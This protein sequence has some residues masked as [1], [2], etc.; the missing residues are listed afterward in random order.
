[1]DGE[2]RVLRTLLIDNYDSFT[3][4]LADYLTRINGL[5]PTVIRNDDPSWM[6]G[7][8]RGFDNVVISPGPGNP[9]RDA[10]FGVC[11][12]AIRSARIPLLGVCLGHQGI[13]RVFGGRVRR[14]PEVFHGRPSAVW[15]SG[16]ELFTGIPS[17]F[18]AVRYHS[19]V[20]ADLP[21]DLEPIA[22]TAG[23]VL[24]GLRHRER[25]IWGVQFH[26]ES[27]C[28]EYGFR[29]L[30]NF[31]SLTRERAAGSSEAALEQA[32]RGPRPSAAPRPERRPAYR[33]LTSVV[34]CDADPE[35]IFGSWY[36]G[37]EHAFWLDSSLT[38]GAD[39]EYS[40][41][42][43]ASGP[44]ARVVTADVWNRRVTVTGHGG[45]RII[46][47]GFL[48]WLDADLAAWVVEPPPDLPFGFCLGWIGY[49]GYELKAEC[50]GD[51]R[52]RAWHA[53]DA[54][55]IFADRALVFDHGHRAV[56]LLALAPVDDE[57]DAAEWLA[58]TGDRLKAFRCRTPGE[59]P[60]APNG[61]RL[62]LRH[63]RSVYLGLIEACQ[64]AIRSGESYEICLT[65]MLSAPARLD[66]WD[67]Y[68]A[69][70]MANPAPFAAYLAINDVSVLSC[71]PERFLRVSADR[72]VETKPIK[73]T[74]PRGR[75]ADEDRRL[76]D[77]LA[78][79]VKDRA[80]NLMIVDLAR[81][82]L[83]RCSVPGSVRVEA[84][85]SVESYAT[86]HQLVSTVR[87]EL[88]PDVST[89]GCVRAAFPGGSMTG[90]PKIRS[91]QIIDELEAGP[92]GV[93]SGALGY[94]SLN[95]AADLSILIRTLV[96]DPDGIEYGVGGAITALS[97]PADEFE[98]T[99]VKARGLVRLL[100]VPFPGDQAGSAVSADSAA[101]AGSADGGP[102]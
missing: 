1:M 59:P 93:Y 23:G 20:A 57:V 71:S 50:G 10:D 30:E 88:R 60:G 102:G 89:V 90:A 52:H 4:N 91:M 64:E 22:W 27:I 69:L 24:M 41:M 100:G 43:D 51:R 58:A 31:A 101:P 62:T 2:A 96:A 44:L 66:P 13:C 70:R 7:L 81:N 15:H 38:G 72:V 82:D 49:L 65:N 26:P 77:E 76:R 36:T 74:R 28:T 35:A 55:M 75:D 8:L 84:M 86:V 16:D 18:P 80:E 48:D 53:P 14:A 9:E 67:S 63:D 21:V 47:G 61:V 5:E 11:G 39:G 56:H 40:I 45:A 92:R 99:A 98:E 95:G 79:S 87:S 25:P 6:P 97:D 37:S 46:E 17:G 32:S 68:R 19:L 78:E 33:V 85:F 3:Y 73:G 54:S 12:A 42:G 83:S 34:D 94:L 29:L